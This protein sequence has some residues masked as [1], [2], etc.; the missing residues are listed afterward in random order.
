MKMSFGRAFLYAHREGLAFLVACPLL[1]LI[2]ILAEFAQHVIEMQIGMYDGLDG[3]KAAEADPLR[4]QFGFVKVLTLSI[5][6]YPVI[7][8]LAGGRDRAAAYRLNPRALALFA[9]PL[10][11]QMALA[12]F[13]L[14]SR[15]ASTTYSIVSFVVML[16]TTPFLLRWF[17]AAPL[18]VWI[19]PARSAREM[20][21]AWL[22]A[23]A[24]GIVAILPL[25]IAHYALGIGAVFAPD[26]AK[27]PMLVL[28]SLLVGWLSATMVASEW[29][30]ANRPGPLTGATPVSTE[31]S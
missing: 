8:F 18:G 12:A 26:W 3:A 28:D 2:P 9:V 30:S 21:P 11:I 10:A 16:L 19:S 29:I 31:A 24:F 27:W 6:G 14:F 15:S 23:F 20:L 7:R 13:D 4:M 1:A 17:T 25:M 22:W 5:M